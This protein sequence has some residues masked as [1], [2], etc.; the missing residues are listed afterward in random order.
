MTDALDAA[1]LP[2]ELGALDYLLHR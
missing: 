1:G 2:T